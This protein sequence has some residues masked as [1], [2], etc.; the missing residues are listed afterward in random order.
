MTEIQSVLLYG[1]LS[2]LFGGGVGWMLGWVQSLFHST[3]E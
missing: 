1:L 3:L 2:Y